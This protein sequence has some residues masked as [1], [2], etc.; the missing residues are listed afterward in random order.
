MIGSVSG[1]EGVLYGSIKAAGNLTGSIFITVDR[2]CYTGNCHVI[3][4]IESQVLST[5]DKII[6]EDITV[7]G[8]PIYEVSNPQG[9]STVI[10]GG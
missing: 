9:G 1:Q 7:E 3:P 2:E 6:T 10:I 5:C 8:I 4:K